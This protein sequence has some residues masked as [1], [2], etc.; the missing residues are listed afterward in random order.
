[1]SVLLKP[2]LIDANQL[3]LAI[4]PYTVEQNL[5]SLEDG[6]LNRARRAI[7]RIIEKQPTIETV[8]VV[9]AHWIRS[10]DADDGYCSV[11]HCDMPMY[12]EDW[13]WKYIETPYCPH[14]GAIMDEVTDE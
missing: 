2:R 8:P 5:D 6:D 10:E 11:C 12:R 13:K 4:S 7:E 14:C 9:H 3:S 1:M